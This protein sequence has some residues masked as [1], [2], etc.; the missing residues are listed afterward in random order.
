MLNNQAMI[1]YDNR[2]KTLTNDAL[3]FALGG[4]SSNYYQQVRSINIRI[5]IN[6]YNKSKQLHKT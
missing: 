2:S 5:Q 6:F 4:A 3:P 1:Y